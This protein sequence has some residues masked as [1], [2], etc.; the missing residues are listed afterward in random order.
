[1]RTDQHYDETFSRAATSGCG[2]DSI[3]FGSGSESGSN[4]GQSQTG[5][6][7]VC[8]T[9]GKQQE[10]A[11]TQPAAPQL[12]EPRVYPEVTGLPQQAFAFDFDFDRGVWVSTD[13]YS[14]LGSGLP[15]D[16]P[17]WLTQGFGFPGSFA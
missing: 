11:Y 10:T 8:K 14:Q 7:E 15:K 17:D 3:T 13:P 6:P 1:V 16:Q 2:S 4:G 12:A 5:S 9:P